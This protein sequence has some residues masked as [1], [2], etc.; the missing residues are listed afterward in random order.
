M[1]S[2]ADRAEVVD[3]LHG[4]VSAGRLTLEDFEEWVSAVYQASTFE[5]LR[6][7]AAHVPARAA[8][9][10]DAPRRRPPLGVAMRI[11]AALAAVGFVVLSADGVDRKALPTIPE[12]ALIDPVAASTSDDSISM[13][14]PPAASEGWFE[15]CDA[16]DAALGAMGQASGR[17]TDRLADVVPS[18][19]IEGFSMVYNSPLAWP[20]VTPPWLRAGL[21]LGGATQGHA[22]GFHAPGY[23]GW[24]VYAFRHP[25][26]DAAL[27]S[28]RSLYTAVV[29]HQGSDPWPLA[30][31]PGAVAASRSIQPAQIFWTSGD[32]LIYLDW[33]VFQ[34]RG[35]AQRPAE[36]A[37]VAVQAALDR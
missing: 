12:P 37:A 28:L 23:G 7:V 16:A 4:V 27:R 15:R 11:V 13:W 6:A 18:A 25:D 8:R 3:R 10:S 9:P 14:Q 33:G 20:D 1:P 34:G 24:T 19:P 5:E 26:P 35:E 32:V 22:A 17:T 21:D 29:C 36:A 31:F 30:A 2:D